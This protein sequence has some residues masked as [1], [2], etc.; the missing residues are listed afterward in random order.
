MDVPWRLLAADVPQEL[1][2]EGRRTVWIVPHRGLCAHGVLGNRETFILDNSQGFLKSHLDQLMHIEV[3]KDRN[4]SLV[5]YVEQSSH[6]SVGRA[7]DITGEK[8]IT[9]L[10]L[11]SL[12]YV[13]CSQ[14]SASAHQKRQAKTRASCVSGEL[15]G[16]ASRLA[17]QYCRN[18]A[19]LQRMRSYS[20]AAVRV[21]GF[22]DKIS[23][24]AL[25]V[26]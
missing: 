12:S 1:S 21:C 26:Q 13:N 14:V 2:A 11:Y 4:S 17:A 18:F 22:L 25:M 6:H 20:C 15:T 23:S 19:G 10:L 24:I 3:L 16:V 8:K 5:C 7:T 9:A